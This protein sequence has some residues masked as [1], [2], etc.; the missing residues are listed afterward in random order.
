MPKMIIG[1][2]LF[3]PVIVRTIMYEAFD[4]TNIQ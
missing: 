3:G 1:C 4:N 2:E